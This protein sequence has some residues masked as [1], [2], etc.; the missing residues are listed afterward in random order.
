MPRMLTVRPSFPHASTVIMAATPL[1]KCNVG[2]PLARAMP[3]VYS[4]AVQP[5]LLHFLALPRFWHRIASCARRKLASLKRIFILENG[6]IQKV[7]K[8]MQ[9]AGKFLVTALL[10]AAMVFV[11]FL[12]GPDIVTSHEARVAQ[13]ARQMAASGWPWSAKPADVA[14]VVLRPREWSGS[15]PIGPPSR[16]MSTRGL[17]PCSTGRSDYKSRRF[18]TGARPSCSACLTYNETTARLQFPR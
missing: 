5:R 14:P 13:P 4:R 9:R 17:S 18:P 8:S 12:S 10:L 6:L 3:R 16:F 11:L 1:K 15:R 2:G 7:Q